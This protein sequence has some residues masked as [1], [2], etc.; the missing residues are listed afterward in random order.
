MKSNCW[1][2]KRC[3][4]EPGGTKVAEFGVC[5][6]AT[7]SRANGVNGGM[8]GGRACWA[9]SGTLC[10][11]RVQ[12]SFAMKLGNCMSCDFYQTV[13]REAGPG[14]TSAQQILNLLV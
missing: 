6:A 13:R 2:Y 1:E 12:G 8:N 4:R 10:G 5:P 9:L 14:M 7:E 11:G 3:G